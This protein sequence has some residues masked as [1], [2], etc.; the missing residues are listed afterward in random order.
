MVIGQSRSKRIFTPK[1]HT[2]EI[3][4]YNNILSNSWKFTCLMSQRFLVF[5][6]PLKMIHKFIILCVYITCVQNK[7]LILEIYASLMHYNLAPFLTLT[8]IFR[9]GHITFSHTYTFC[10]QIQFQHFTA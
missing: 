2:F 5:I 1:V 10:V 8:L 6:L 7:F 4:I 3:F 9:F